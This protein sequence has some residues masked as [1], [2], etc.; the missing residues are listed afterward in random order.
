MN[1]QNHLTMNMKTQM[2]K[3]QLNH[4]V[5]PLRELIIYGSLVFLIIFLQFPYFLLRYS[6]LHQ[7]YLA[8]LRVLDAYSLD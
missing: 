5:L 6:R 1:S 4:L 8:Y 7:N 3:I 2:R